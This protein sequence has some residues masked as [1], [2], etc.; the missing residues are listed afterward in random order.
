MFAN[1]AQRPLDA[2]T[3]NRNEKKVVKTNSDESCRW[4]GT[5]EQ[6]GFAA[7]TR[8]HTHDEPR[9]NEYFT[10]AVADSVHPMSKVGHKLDLSAFTQAV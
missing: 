5:P 10:P 1:V 3:A 8:T 9:Y 4:S 6:D 2:K 7:A